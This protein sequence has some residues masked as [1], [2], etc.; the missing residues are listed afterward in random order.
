MVWIWHLLLHTTE[1]FLKFCN[2]EIKDTEGYLILINTSGM[3]QHV[4]LSN[5]TTLGNDTLRVL[6]AAPNS[7]FKVGYVQKKKINCLP[8]K[9]Y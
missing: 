2:R 5:F 7:R 3:E 1:T 9:I 6:T 4:S 8:Y